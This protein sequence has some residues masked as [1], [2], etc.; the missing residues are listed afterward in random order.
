M[1]TISQYRGKWKCQVRKTGYPTQTRSFDLRAAAVAWGQEVETSMNRGAFAGNTTKQSTTVRDVLERYL[2]E[3]S[4]KKAYSAADV[5]RA[6]PVLAAL[7]A[8]HVHKLTHTHLADFKRSR[9]ALRS[10]QTVTHELNLLHR[11]YVIASTEWG[12]V[13]PNGIP[14]TSRPT[15]PRSNGTR[16]RPSQIELIVKATE[17]EQLKHIVPFAI[18]TAMRRSELMSVRW[19]QVDLE[20]RSIFLIR[21]KNGQSRTIPLSTAAL[22]V[23]HSIPRKTTGPV[24]TLA[25]SSVSQAFQRAVERAGLDHVRFHDLRHEA[26]SRLFERGLNVIEVARITG[27]ITLSMLDRY[28]HLDVEGLVDKLR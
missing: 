22:K 26:T 9:L 20:R 15:L 28:T 3:E 8:Y 1:A 23:L 11:A 12:I 4:T 7:G 10:P 14:K 21:T 13:L 17:S 2:A 19:E 25:A 6:K 5:S 27:H 24:F 18:E 16:I